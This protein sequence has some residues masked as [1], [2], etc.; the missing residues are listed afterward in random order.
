MSDN[1]RRNL[2][3]GLNALLGSDEE[4]NQIMSGEQ[5]TT[6]AIANIQPSPFQPRRNFNE[7]NIADLAES[8][9]EKG[10]LQPLIVRK[11]GVENVYEIIAGERRFRASKIVGLEELPVIIKDLSDKE[12][13]EVALVENLQRQDL[14]PLEEAEGY[15][16]LI[17]EFGHTQEALAKVVGKSR[18]HVANTLR[19]LNL[20]EEVKK[21]L[22]SGEL[23]SGHARALL[24]SENML[25]LA[26]EVIKKGLNVRQTESLVKQPSAKDAV[27][28]PKAVVKEK[29]SD[30]LALEKE[31]SKL[32]GLKVFIRSQGRGGEI[33]IK[34]GS[35]EE[36]DDILF[37]LG[38]MAKNSDMDN[39][40]L[41]EDLTEAE[42][43]PEIYDETATASIVDDFAETI[44][45]AE[46]SEQEVFEETAVPEE[47]NLISSEIDED[48]V[49]P[50]DD[51]E[52][53]IEEA[54]N[55]EIEEQADLV[56]SVENTDVV[57]EDTS[58]VVG[59]FIEEFDVAGEA[60]EE[61]METEENAVS[62]NIEAEVEEFLSDM[63]GAAEDDIVTE[64]LANDA[65]SEEDAV[66]EIDDGVQIE[67]ATGEEPVFEEQNEAL[68][69]EEEAV[70]TPESETEEDWAV[71]LDTVIGLDDET[72]E[73]AKTEEDAIP[74]DAWAKALKLD[75]EDEII[76]EA[77]PENKA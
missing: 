38:K 62:E 48:L 8:I 75:G 25:E 44:E 66:V 71:G 33:A 9:R 10:I 13:L 31:L 58:E 24:N 74:D 18:S 64:V 5:L 6:I 41:V 3:R 60:Q 23:S 67:E 73:E 26:Q 40:E 68:N 19:L 7:D 57:M 61:Y 16:K 56:D 39:S 11:S 65:D 4:E 36:L 30:I 34:Y 37:K 28:K 12:V 20:P 72:E 55:I 50:V 63:A 77:A 52:T 17:N 54:Y 32:M 35:L 27:T 49:N 43:A 76:E 15:Q 2:G 46:L 59:E 21:M 1:K 42:V 45:E 51:S 53:A 29:D 69:P 47:E 14:S 70:I 22:Q